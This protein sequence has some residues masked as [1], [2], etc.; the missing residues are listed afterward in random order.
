MKIHILFEFISTA[1]GGGNQF[2][3]AVKEYF[4]SKNCY[5]DEPGLADIIMYNSYQYIPELLEMKLKYPNKIFVHR[6]DGPIRLYNEL[7]DRRDHVTNQA[8]RLIADG[9]IYQS[10][11]SKLRNNEMGLATNLNETTILNAPNPSHFSKV[12]KLDFK[13]SG[14]IKIIATSWSNN[15]KK[16]FGVY[17]WLDNNLDF[18]KYHMTFVGNSPIEFKNIEHKA[19]MNSEKIAME[20]KQNDIFLTASQKD[21]CSNSLIEAMHCGLP[22]IA[23]NDGGHTEIVGD[24]GRVFEKTEDLPTHLDEVCHNYSKYQDQLQL[25]VMAEVGERYFVFL[26]ELV[27]KKNSGAY[28][29]KTMNWL[30]TLRLKKTLFFWKLSEKIKSRL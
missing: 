25:P 29:V 16:G 20:L 11:W 2:L 10:H 14:K 18:D 12:E 21:P 27:N 19:P 8:N 6:I 28:K 22:P 15:L 7:S 30:T 13:H 1:S 26:E 9:T 5:V 3:K 23:L 4:E 24:A 17:Q